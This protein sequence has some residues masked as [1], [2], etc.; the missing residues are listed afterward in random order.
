MNFLKLIS[1][2]NL[3]WIALAQ[4][5]FH[6]GLLKQQGLSLALQDWQ[7]FLLL[8]AC[9]CIAGGG[10]LI[11]AIMDK[12]TS[13]TYR[14]GENGLIKSSFE[15]KAYNLYATLN[16][17]GVGVGFYLSNFIG[18]ASFAGMFIIVAATLYLYASSLK[19]NLLV[20][21]I[22]IAILLALSILIVGIYDLLPIITPENQPF[23]KVLFEIFIDY[24]SF[25]FLIS[26]IRELLSDFTTIENDLDRGSKTLPIIIGRKNTKIVISVLIALLVIFTA[27]YSYTYMFA[28]DLY[29]ASFY[30]MALILAPLIYSLIRLWSVS[31]IKEYNQLNL[32]LKAVMIFGVLSLLVV[33]FTK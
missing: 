3:I 28:N 17:I 15:A 20:G 5:I 27:R 21:D 11:Y 33:E 30:I 29:I 24:A 10:F 31:E 23:L 2:R 4:L 32:I 16:I 12:N 6:F 9:V 25:V 8:L 26:F 18:K 7:F 19:K 14:S 22:I 13:P 1:L